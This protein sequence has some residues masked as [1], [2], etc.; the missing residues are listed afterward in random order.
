[1][2]VEKETSEILH[3]ELKKVE[4][5]KQQIEAEEAKRK[6]LLQK[7]ANP[8]RQKE[9]ENMSQQEEDELRQRLLDKIK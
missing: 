5:V 1:M 7:I 2:K 4:D 3:Q 6:A 9:L 8:E